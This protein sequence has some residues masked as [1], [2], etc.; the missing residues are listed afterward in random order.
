[1]LIIQILLILGVAIGGAMLMR[2]SSNAR[3]QAVR[4]LMLLTFVAFAVTS[5]LV[6]ELVSDVARAVGVGRGADLLLY[7][8]FVAFIGFIATTYRR[9]REM[10]RQLTILTRR[11]A[12]DEVPAPLATFSR[13][14]GLTSDDRTTTFPPAEA[15][16]PVA[17]SDQ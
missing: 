9:F 5:I 1:M 2:A 17:R 7:G 4:R 12:L 10:E 6:P 8:L 14:P 13:R 15:R 11:L 3:H 16:P